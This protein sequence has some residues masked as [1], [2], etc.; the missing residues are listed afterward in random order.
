MHS[1][2]YTSRPYGVLM[3][4]KGK[5]RKRRKPGAA[6]GA[7]TSSAPTSA[8]LKPDGSS[9]SSSSSSP[10]STAAVEGAGPL[11]DVL[12]GDRGIEAL[13][14]DDWSDMPANDGMVKS[15]VSLAII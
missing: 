14:S 2:G 6:D 12:E 1:S 15:N 8:K 13:S 10:D 7:S 4:T 3:A 5:K 11:G 9:S